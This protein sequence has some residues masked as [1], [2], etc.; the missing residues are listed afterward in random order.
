MENYL[1]TI[2]NAGD[3]DS[4]GPCGAIHPLDV[5]DARQE[6]GG[7][8][9][10]NPASRSVS[11][12]CGQ[13]P[14]QRLEILNL[15]GKRI[16]KMDLQGQKEVSVSLYDMPVGMYFIRVQTRAGTFFQKLVKI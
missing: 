4:T 10:P 16:K 5:E 15:E 12:R 14:M 11:I 7:E 6:V 1:T 3:P 2:R 13:S 8:V 9:W